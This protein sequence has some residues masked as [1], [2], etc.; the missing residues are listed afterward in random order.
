MIDAL[1]IKKDPYHDESGRFA[2]GGESSGTLEGTQS[3]RLTHAAES[4]E[5]GLSQPE[6]EGLESYVGGNHPSMNG[7][8]RDRENYEDEWGSLGADVAFKEQ[9]DQNFND[10]LGDAL[11]KT[12][13]PEDV[14]AYRGLSQEGQPVQFFSDHIGKTF[15]DPAFVSTSLDP[16]IAHE[17]SSGHIIME[18]HIPKGTHAAYLGKISAYP[19]EKELLL[20]KGLR[21]RV[22]AVEQKPGSPAIVKIEALL[23][24]SKKQ[25]DV[26]EQK[27]NHAHS[28]TT[29]EFSS[30]DAMGKN[31]ASFPEEIWDQSSRTSFGESQ[32]DTFEME[33]Q[34]HNHYFVKKMMDY[35]N[36]FGTQQEQAAHEVAAV[37]LANAMGLSDHVADA[38][39]TYDAPGGDGVYSIKTWADDF[40]S[41]GEKDL[42]NIRKLPDTK[43]AS[44]LLFEYLTGD[45]DRHIGNYAIGR[46]GVLIEHDFSTAFPKDTK[47]NYK[48]AL[49]AATYGSGGGVNFIP[50]ETLSKIVG[51]KAAI[52]ASVK[53]TL[54][55]EEFTTFKKRFG[56]IVTASKKSTHW[57]QFGPLAEKAK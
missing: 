54:T 52:F 32:N 34:Q 16:G 42:E 33:D 44:L 48:S 20:Q 25:G 5:A 57:G 43:K 14:E 1:A 10:N 7:L 11:Q 23:P 47:F 17:F 56:V 29:G 13:L 30:G 45:A 55:P 12:S 53:K 31:G 3:D 51:D 24:A 41:V 46:D 26:Q 40:D 8:L 39:N 37:D 49:F 50:K 21:F 4:W 18:M 19:E 15:T 27:Y 35:T 38:I 2:T 28:E 36:E 9:R 6:R 22:T